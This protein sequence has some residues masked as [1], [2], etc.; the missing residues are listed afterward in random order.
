MFWSLVA[1]GNKRNKRKLRVV[2]VI[3]FGSIKR[4]KRV[5]LGMFYIDSNSM[6]GRESNGAIIYICCVSNSKMTG[7]VWGCVELPKEEKQNKN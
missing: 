5:R 1:T 6:Q 2:L 4:G 3:H 7:C